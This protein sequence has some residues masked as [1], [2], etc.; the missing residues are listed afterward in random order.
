MQIRLLALFAVVLAGCAQASQDA[1]PRKGFFGAQFGPLTPELRKEKKLP[2]AG[3]LLIV[4]VPP[5]TTASKGGFKPQDVLMEAN[6]KKLNVL[7]EL[8]GVIAAVKTGEKMAFKFI[9]DGKEESVSVEI[10]PRPADKGD[11]YEVIYDHVVSHGARIRTLVSKPKG[12]EGKRPVMFLIQGIGYSSQDNPLSGPSAYSRIL[13][14]FN[15]KGFVTVRVDKPGLGDSEGGPANTVDYERDLDSFRQGLKS[16]DKYDFIDKNNI[17][18]FGHSMGGCEGPILATEFPIKGIAV[19]GTV[20]RTWFE[21]MLQNMRNQ[22]ALG[23]Q[24]HGQLDAEMRN[25]FSVFHLIF[26]EGM[27]VAEAKT[28]YPKYAGAIDAFTPDGKTMSG[29][30]LAFWRQ[31][32]NYD[33]SKYWEKVKA[34][35]LSMWGENEFIAYEVDH[36]MIVE[37]V[38]KNNPGKAKYVKV[39]ASDHGFRQT[40]SMLDS[41]QTWGQPGKPFNPAVI[42]MLTSWVDEVMKKA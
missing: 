29:M 27:E 40:T 22:G 6:G 10:Q 14:A 5:D 31:C 8:G 39:P 4:A 28:K 15:D 17:F 12:F 25:M 19:Y 9:R 23:G 24:S 26:N 16:L 41:F 2:D 38:N 35:V 21:Y 37:I 34:N 1:L 18:I 33:Y 20:T 36:P 32:F 13:K 11:N 30:P 42:E 3:G 7:Q